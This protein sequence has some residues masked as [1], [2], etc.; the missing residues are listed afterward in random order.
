MWKRYLH[1]DCW[2]VSCQGCPCSK[3][4]TGSDI[5]R[6]SSPVLHRVPH[7]FRSDDERIGTDW[8][9]VSTRPFQPMLQHF[10]ISG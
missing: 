3:Y 2:C 4:C 1:D 7:L 10:L 9:A 6:P 8:I 5:V